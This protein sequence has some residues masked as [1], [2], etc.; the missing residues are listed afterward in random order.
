[1]G[2]KPYK[3]KH[4]W[5]GEGQPERVL[6]ENGVPLGRPPK[7]RYSANWGGRREGSGRKKGDTL[8]STIAFRVPADIKEKATK[9]NERGFS[10][11]DIFLTA[12]KDLCKTL[13]L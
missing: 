9:L 4:D 11:R 10:P 2:K 6:S 5:K 1:M 7:H 12:I 8:T 3:V 13:G